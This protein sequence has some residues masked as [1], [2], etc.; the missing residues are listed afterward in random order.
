MDIVL[1]HRN[2]LGHWL[3]NFNILIEQSPRL[4][5]RVP[6]RL[7]ALFVKLLFQP[8]GLAFS[9][10]RRKLALRSRLPVLLNSHL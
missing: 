1:L 6:F 4:L 10:L 3:Q 9:P 2:P 7:I 8:L 5:R